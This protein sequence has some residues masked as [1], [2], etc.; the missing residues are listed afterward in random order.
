MAK[1]KT[2]KNFKIQ[3]GWKYLESRR[4]HVDF[5]IELPLVGITQLLNCG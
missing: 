4:F 3:I 1:T 2:K 5:N